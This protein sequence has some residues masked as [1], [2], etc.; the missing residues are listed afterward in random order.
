MENPLSDSEREE[1]WDE[2]SHVL[3]DEDVDYR[4]FININPAQLKYIF[5][6]EMLLYCGPLM[7]STTPPMGEGF[8]QE[9]MVAYIRAE[10]ERNKKSIIARFFHKVLVLLFHW[11]FKECWKEV[12]DELKRPMEQLRMAEQGDANAQ[13]ETARSYWL[14]RFGK[15]TEKNHAET[16]KWIQKAAEQGHAMAQFVIGKMYLYGMQVEQSDIKAAEW[17]Q[18]AAEQGVAGAQSMLGLMYKEARG[19]EQNFMKAIEWSLKAAEQDN[20]DAQFNLGMIYQ[21]GGDGIERDDAKAAEWYRKSAEQRW[22]KIT[23][24]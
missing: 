14:E 15:D 8:S 17:I 10:L 4:K 3:V 19:V 12:S 9:E 5:F 7:L 6:N 23:G 22:K 20:S 11:F 1:I 13:F 16:L 24:R 18:K 21:E 2:L